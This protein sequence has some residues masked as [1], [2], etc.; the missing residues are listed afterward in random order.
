MKMLTVK[1]KHD[2]IKLNLNQVYYIQSQAD[3]PHVLALVTREKTYEVRATLSNLEKDLGD[4]FFRCHRNCLVNVSKIVGFNK[5]ERRILF[6]PKSLGPIYYSR[7]QYMQL[8][9]LW[10]KK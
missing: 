8:Y 2:I 7:R 3:K 4:F 6:N 1:E 9:Q 10:L 5:K